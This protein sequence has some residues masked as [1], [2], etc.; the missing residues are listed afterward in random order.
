MPS[1]QQQE[2][3]RPAERGEAEAAAAADTTQATT[4]ERRGLKRKVNTTDKDGT[5]P[6]RK[7]NEAVV[8]PQLANLAQTAP[9]LAPSLKRA[10]CAAPSVLVVQPASAVQ[11][12]HASPPLSVVKA[13]APEAA[14]VPALTA[15]GELARGVQA[16][17]LELSP[18]SLEEEP[19]DEDEAVPLSGSAPSVT[20]AGEVECRQKARPSSWSVPL[21]SV[22]Q[23]PGSQDL[24][25]ITLD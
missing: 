13:S 4:L 22:G 10:T 19:E 14:P 16:L 24:S 12:V 6:T 11:A 7:A 2:D 1:Q 20:P 25:E 23:A 21:A 17:P 15:F 9:V 5:V 3:P 18:S 8:A